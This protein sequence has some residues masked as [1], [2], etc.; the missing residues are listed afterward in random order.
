MF[1]RYHHPDCLIG[2]VRESLYTQGF[3]TTATSVA[4]VAYYRSEMATRGWRET[5]D[6]YLV[7][8]DED[9][10]AEWVRGDLRA[11]VGIAR[12]NPATPTTYPTVFR[13]RLMAPPRCYPQ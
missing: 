13:L 12:P 1:N 8:I 10:S 7:W 3:G 5:P 6:R 4:V 11:Q 9:V 2:N